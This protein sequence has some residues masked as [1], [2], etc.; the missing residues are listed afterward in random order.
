MVGVRVGRLLENRSFR[1]IVN[2]GVETDYDY[3]CLSLKSIHSV[4]GSGLTPYANMER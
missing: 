1:L 2:L 3:A 4:V